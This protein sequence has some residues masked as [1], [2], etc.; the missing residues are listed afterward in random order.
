MKDTGLYDAIWI[1]VAIFACAA[2]GWSQEINGIVVDPEQKPIPQA[3]ISILDEAREITSTVS[4]R[5]GRFSIQSAAGKTLRVSATGFERSE[6]RLSDFKTP[7]VVVLHPQSVHED[8]VVS[9]ARTSTRLSETPASVVV[10]NQSAISTTAAQTVD[11]ALR[12]VPGFSLFRRSS[13]KTANPTTQGASLRGIGGSGAARTSVLFDGTSLNDPFGGWTYWSRIPVIAIDEVEVLRGGASSLYGNS[14][15]SGAINLNP[16][17][18]DSHALRFET[19]GG[20]QETFTGSLYAAYGKHGWNLDLAG[21]SFQTA[22]YI[23]AAVGQRG[24]VDSHANSR[25]NSGFMTLERRFSD[26]VRIFGRGN[27]FAERRDNGTSLTTNRTYFRQGVIGADFANAELGTFELR[28]SIDAQIYDQTFSSVS[29]DRNIENLNRIQRVPSESYAANLIW[30]RPIEKHAISA[31]LDLRRVKGF[32]DETAVS[33]GRS[34]AFISSG[35]REFS[36]G[37]SAQ[38]FWHLTQK[39]NVNVGGRFDSW[40]EYGASASTRG[41]T[42]GQSTITN[43]PNRNKQAFSPRIASIYQIYDA[44]SIYAAFSTAFRAP[45]LNE[46][47]RAFRVGNVLTLANENLEAE[48]SRTIESGANFTG[49]SKRL[50]LRGSIFWTDVSN[51][52]V[53][54]TLTSTPTL[55]TR[56]R[57]NVGKTHTKGFEIDSEFVFSPKLRVSTGYLFSDSRVSSFPGNAALVHKFL[58]QVARNQFTF[59]GTYR[60]RNSI[61]LSFQG[62]ASGSQFE[63]D[64]ST[65]RLRPYFTVDAFVSYKFPKKVEIFASA[66]NLFNSRFDI[67]LTPNRTIAP[68]RFVRVGLR[69]DLARNSR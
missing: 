37:V 51:P 25:H 10:L 22:G 27:L 38:D 30:N 67:G 55:I 66:E 9:I 34:T 48:T 60:P 36:F 6:I 46:L 4:D 61:S 24:S 33:S 49:L 31:S 69:F 3:S 13:S 54:V 15:L 44:V 29:P 57:Q 50:N 12:Q 58:P 28:S 43:F 17:K 21:E 14:A 65:L 42:G 68:P 8:V 64:L 63:D 59:Q 19:S 26:A 16:P 41:L 47:Y 53:S 7:F 52:V 56:Q 20:G 39:L 45:S 18:Q 2:A 62:R 23:P 5:Q 35:G 1:L 40:R 11:D 32:S